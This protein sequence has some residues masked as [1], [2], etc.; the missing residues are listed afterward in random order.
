MIS[1]ECLHCGEVSERLVSHDELGWHSA[2]VPCDS[3]FDVDIHGDYLVSLW[4]HDSDRAIDDITEE[5][6]IDITVEQFTFYK[7]PSM[8]ENKELLQKLS[9]YEGMVYELHEV[10][11]GKSIAL[12]VFS[13]QSIYD[14]IWYAGE[15]SEKIGKD[16]RP[17]AQAINGEVGVGDTVIVAPHDDYGHLIGEVIYIDRLGTPEHDTGNPGDDVHVN[18]RAFNYPPW[19]QIAFAEHFSE[20]SGGDDR[21]FNELPLDDVIIAPDALITLTGVSAERINRMVTDF[22]EADSF[23]EEIMAQYGLALPQE[24]QPGVGIEM[25]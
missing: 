6:K 22:D 25:R 24:D 8:E 9:A 19:Q 14:D 17:T 4:P 11:S 10:N 20:L 2:C 7:T 5:E 3:T 23:C 12:G 16:S 15:H 18:F 13:A 21:H 1:C